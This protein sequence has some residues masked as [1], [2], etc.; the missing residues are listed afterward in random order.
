MN[1]LNTLMSKTI[2]FPLSNLNNKYG[3]TRNVPH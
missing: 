1:A 3:N 2:Q